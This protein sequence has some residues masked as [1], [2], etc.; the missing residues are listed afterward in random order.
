MPFDEDWLK[1]PGELRPERQANR[2]PNA[3][4]SRPYQQPRS[5]NSG[6]SRGALLGSLRQQA[7]G[8]LSTASS[9]TSWVLIFAVIWIGSRMID[10]TNS[11]TTQELPVPDAVTAAR[12][13]QGDPLVS[14]SFAD[15]IDRFVKQQLEVLE[16]P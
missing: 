11:E 16:M 1:L 14:D 15:Q 13:D 7:R 3:G 4:R 8:L 10:R 2:N 12:T 6:S 9:W 5:R